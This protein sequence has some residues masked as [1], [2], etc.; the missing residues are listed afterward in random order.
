MAEVTQ[1]E[2]DSIREAQDDFMPGI[3]TVQRQRAQGDGQYARQTLYDVIPYR[4]IPGFGRWGVV[5]DRYVGIT[6]FRLTV[7]WDYELHAGDVFI[8]ENGTT[9]E[10]RD[11]LSHSSYQTAVQ[12]L[13]DLVTD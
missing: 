12:A 2:I 4:L 13:V 11:V 10:I 1:P 7:P 8:D 9:Y 6:A 3:G 5:A